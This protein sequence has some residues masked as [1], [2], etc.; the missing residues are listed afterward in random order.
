VRGDLQ[1]DDWKMNRPLVAIKIVHTAVWAVFVACIVFA[2][3]AAVF[4]RFDWA[5]ALISAVL[6]ECGVLALNRGKCPLTD[7]AARYTSERADNFDIFLPLGLA[8]HNKTI[9][10]GLFLAGGVFVLWRWFSRH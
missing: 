6:V 5:I 4:G 1:E 10:G 2:P 8:R 3:V 9:F 7:V